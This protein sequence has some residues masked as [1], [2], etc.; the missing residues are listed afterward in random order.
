MSRLQERLSS[1][2][3][4]A[5]KQLTKS[6][7]RFWGISPREW[8]WGAAL[9]LVVT[10]EAPQAIDRVWVMLHPPP[11]PP[12]IPMKVEWEE[13]AIMANGHWRVT[14]E[15]T[16]REQC[17]TVVWRRF[18]RAEG[19]EDFELQTVASSTGA[20]TPPTAVGTRRAPGT[21]LD[22][23]EYEPLPGLRGVRMVTATFA[24]C[25]SGFSGSVGLYAT[26]FDWTGIEAPPSRR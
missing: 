7:R 3:S 9:C 22:W 24:D 21:Y 6:S 5:A 25:P 4:Q 17:G 14:R 13:G 26:P 23:W 10:V 11:P 18:F 12:P 2:S 19:R 1:A 15:L 16:I 8:L 20:L